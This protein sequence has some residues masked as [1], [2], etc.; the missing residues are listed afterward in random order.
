MNSLKR[1]TKRQHVS[2]TVLTGRDDTRKVPMH[3]DNAFPPETEVLQ[4]ILK[5]TC[6]SLLLIFTFYKL[7]NN[8]IN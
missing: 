1:L 2:E 8:L 6:I 7:L 5:N 3:Q 4:S